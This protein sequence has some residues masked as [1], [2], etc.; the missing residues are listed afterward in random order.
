MRAGGTTS[1]VCARQIQVDLPR[2]KEHLNKVIGRPDT[3]GW[4][5]LSLPV[6][7]RPLLTLW[8]GEPQ[9]VGRS[10]PSRALGRAA[11]RRNKDAE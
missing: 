10:C 2:L 4:P 5:Y 9:R 3:E 11:S 7:L 6:S 1:Y 8:G